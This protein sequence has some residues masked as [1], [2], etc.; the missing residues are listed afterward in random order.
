MF[1]LS[2]YGHY[3]WEYGVRMDHS[4]KYLNL[5]QVYGQGLSIA[6]FIPSFPDTFRFAPIRPESKIIWP[7]IEHPNNVTYI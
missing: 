1:P 2:S 7:I 4:R 5:G 3:Q 6:N